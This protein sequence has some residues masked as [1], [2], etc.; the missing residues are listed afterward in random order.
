M[1]QRKSPS[2]SPR[3]GIDHEA[4]LAERAKNGSAT[5]RRTICGC[6][7][8]VHCKSVTALSETFWCEKCR[9]LVVVL[10]RQKTTD[11]PPY[12]TS[13]GSLYRTET[14]R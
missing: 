7:G 8:R 14:C 4:L 9:D 2:S 11:S 12:Y 6:G 10:V 1:P 3:S 13:D 5:G